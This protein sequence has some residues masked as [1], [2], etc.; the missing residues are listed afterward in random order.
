[1]R[2]TFV[3]LAL[4]FVFIWAVSF[5]AFHVAGF[6]IHLFLILAVICFIMHLVRSRGTV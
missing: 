3:V 2:Y 6:L 4:I 1:M 5:I